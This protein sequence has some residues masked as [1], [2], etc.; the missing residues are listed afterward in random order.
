VRPPARAGETGLGAVDGSWQLLAPAAGWRRGIGMPHTSCGLGTDEVGKTAETGEPAEGDEEVVVVS[1]LP[2]LRVSH[3]SR[4]DVLLLCGVAVAREKAKG[5][6][7]LAS[8]WMTCSHL[9]PGD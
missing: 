2:E 6:E 5:G 1:K 9:G 7:P 4:V 8:W 3:D